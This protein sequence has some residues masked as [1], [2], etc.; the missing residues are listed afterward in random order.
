MPPVSSRTTNRSVPSIRSL[1]SGLASNS[2][3]L[4]RTGLRFA[5]SPRPLRSPSNPCS[6]RGASGSVVS[7]LGPPTAQSRTASDSRHASS[8]SSVSGVPYSSIEAPPIACAAISK[9]P[10]ACSTRYAASASS[11][12]MPSPGSRAIRWLMPETLCG[13]DIQ[14]HVAQLV[15]V[16]GRVQDSLGEGLPQVLGQPRPVSGETTRRD[17]VAWVLR[18]EDRD[19]L[20][21]TPDLVE[22]CAAKPPRGLLRPVEVPRS[23]VRDVSGERLIGRGCLYGLDP[24]LHVAAAAALSDQP[25]VR[26]DD[27]SQVREEPVVVA[28]PV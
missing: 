28:D 23:V 15:G 7:H 18:E 14:P 3:S 5:N 10:T 6:G 2:A 8:T 20:Q 12:P 19:L 4:G 26:A 11:G 13:V 1:L 27:G 16:L 24:R 22:S 17:E 21:P 25:A 9:S